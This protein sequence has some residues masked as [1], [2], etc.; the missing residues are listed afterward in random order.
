MF[1]FGTL[2]ASRTVTAIGT[3]VVI[4][5]AVHEGTVQWP[6]APLVNSCPFISSTKRYEPA[7]TA[8]NTC[9][10]TAVCTYPPAPPPVFSHH[11]VFPCCGVPL[12]STTVTSTRV[13]VIWAVVHPG[14]T[15]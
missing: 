4:V 2:L 14:V 3:V 5:A 15:Q 10:L 13:I 11:T 9:P 12:V 6:A 8:I 1:G 7:G